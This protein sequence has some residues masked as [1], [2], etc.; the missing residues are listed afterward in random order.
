[1]RIMSWTEQK[2]QMLKDMWGHGYSASEIATA[3]L[4]NR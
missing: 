4:P 3:A 1:M 2:I